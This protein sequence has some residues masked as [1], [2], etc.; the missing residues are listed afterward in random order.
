MGKIQILDRATANRIA[1]GE[2]VERPASVV[3]ELCENALDAEA[4]LITVRIRNGG[5]R[6]IQV[7]DNGKGM[8][9]DDL[10]LAVREHATSKL[11]SIHDLEQIET[12]GFRGEALPSIA[13]VSKLRI[14]SREA[15]AEEGA[16][17]EMEGGRL[18]AHRPQAVN[19]GTQI[20]VHN[21]F[22]N[23]PARYKFLK[24]DAAEAGRVSRVIT[25]L[26]LARPDVSFRLF[27]QNE[28]LI[29]TPGNNDLL[30]AVCALFGASV[31][32]RMV[33][34][35][36]DENETCRCRGYLGAPDAARKSRI[37]QYL[38]VNK[39]VIESKVVIRAV[40]DAYKSFLVKGHFPAFILEL[41]LPPAYLDVN[42]HPQKTEVRFWNESSLYRSVYQQVKNSLFSALSSIHDGKDGL[43]RREAFECSGNPQDSLPSEKEKKLTSTQSLQPK[44]DAP[45]FGEKD[46]SPQDAPPTSTNSGN[47]LCEFVPHSREAAAERDPRVIA[48]GKPG[49]VSLFQNSDHP[50]LLLR[51]E[52]T[53]Y[54]RK[55]EVFDAVRQ[56]FDAWLADEQES[57]GEASFA[58]AK[59]ASAPP[60]EATFSF[61][62]VDRVH[63]KRVQTPKNAQSDEPRCMSPHDGKND[64][65]GL[66]ASVASSPVAVLKKARYVGQLFGTY[67][68][69]ESSEAVYLV[70]QHAAHEKV[71]YE[72]FRRRFYNAREGKEMPSQIL[73]NPLPL[74]LNSE[75]K[76]A[77][78]ARKAF[79]EKMAFRFE[80][81]DGEIFLCAHPFHK[82]RLRPETLLKEILDAEISEENSYQYAERD[83]IDLM[84][85]TMGCKA[86]V[87]AHDTLTEAEVQALVE[88]LQ[89]LENPY[90]CPHG[91]P[92]IIKR[93]LRE[94]EE[95]FQR[96]VN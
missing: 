88:A 2:V 3:K 72:E 39:R 21:L 86:A 51:E 95:A 76:N 9:F 13:S 45:V 35:L 27:S 83:R 30:S 5:I 94:I 37:M 68:L 23:T 47:P 4:S 18:L 52:A 7:S 87:K 31:A 70:D 90:H 11:K 58:D 53:R 91:R 1:A 69:F 10:R 96:I 66:D 82:L 24:K 38:F 19:K 17:I 50:D 73:L 84:L 89:K 56:E 36:P 67:L 81:R 25:E 14:E 85:A 32:E 64:G 28:E 20:W 78:C 49:E 16:F 60:R 54:D 80:E 22:F 48:F 12:M 15:D 33:P 75:E 41:E 79:L 44:V 63:K 55:T 62:S 40:E 92:V 46:E 6:L 26:A 71:L 59:A 61:P 57:G 8:G 65:A 77:F 42:V 74:S 29:H 34:I 43:R 93:S